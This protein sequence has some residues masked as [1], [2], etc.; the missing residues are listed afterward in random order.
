MFNLNK[1]GLY[2]PASIPSCIATLA[3]AVLLVVRPVILSNQDI[4]AEVF[5]RRLPFDKRKFV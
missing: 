3:S 2:H 1:I 4:S 5:L